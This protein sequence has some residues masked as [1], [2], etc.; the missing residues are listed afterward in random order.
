[1]VMSRPSDKRRILLAITEASP[2]QDLWRA[3]VD[4]LEGAHG[5]LTT[6]FVSDD[7][8]HR[9][10]SLP[11]TREVS[12]VSGDSENFTRER[13]QQIDEDTVGR[14]HRELEKLASEAELPFAFEVLPEHDASKLREIVSVQHDVLILPSFL[15]SRP[16][17]AELMRVKCRVYYVDAEEEDTTD[18]ED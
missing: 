7:R 16:I 6:V 9:A 1:M 15:K 18:T 14:T 4:Y 10:A 3:V 8:W 11:F 2:L 5:E 13:A 17:Y 12:K